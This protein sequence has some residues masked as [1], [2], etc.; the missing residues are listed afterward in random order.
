[1]SSRVYEI[2]EVTASTTIAFPEGEAYL[3]VG[4]KGMVTSTGWSNP[5]LSRFIYLNP[6]KDG[7]Q[8]F[9]FRAEPPA[10][11][12]ITQ[13][14]VTPIMVIELKSLPSWAKG[15][16]VHSVTNYKEFRLP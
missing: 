1:M 4:A 11:G 3:V 5:T 9:D 13:P 15:I 14:V 10:E 7:I 2:V 8:D 6:P 16:R 12:T